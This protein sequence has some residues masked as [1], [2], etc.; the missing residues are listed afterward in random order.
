MIQMHEYNRF[1]S[2]FGIFPYKKPQ[3]YS[4]Q[5][6]IS[7]ESALRKW[8]QHFYFRFVVIC[9]QHSIVCLFWA[10][11]EILWVLDQTT[12]FKSKNKNKNPNKL[13]RFENRNKNGKRSIQWFSRICVVKACVHTNR[14]NVK[15]HFLLWKK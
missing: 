5:Y 4:L 1:D 6:T 3:S 2:M 11:E 14:H 7:K 10:H 8:I 9:C 12:A 13:F 15:A